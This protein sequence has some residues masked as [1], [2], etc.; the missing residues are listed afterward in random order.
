MK[1]IM[2]V[3][4]CALLA[5]G[6]I[7][8]QSKSIEE[9]CKKLS[10]HENMVGN[11]LQEKTIAKNNRS[12]KSNGRFIFCPE[13][14]MWETQKPFKVTMIVTKQ[15]FVQIGA[16]GKRKSMD[17]SSNQTFASVSSKIGALFSGDAEVLTNDFVVDYKS[18]NGKWEA[19]LTP[20]SKTVAS[21]MKSV[22]ISGAES[23]NEATIEKIVM[24]ESN[25]NTTGYY[26]SEQRYPKELSAD[27]KAYFAE[28]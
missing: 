16:D 4:A 25:N 28:K 18:A 7:F 14:F 27:E 6:N 23:A 22:L 19:I 21:V 20:K 11:F 2:L 26:L 3:A 9:F 10:V 12:L 13:G 15:S 5:C 8:A 17:V 1:K 24:T